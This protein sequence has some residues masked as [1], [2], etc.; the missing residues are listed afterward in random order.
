[1][2]IC[3]E[4]LGD[5]VQDVNEK[6]NVDI[7]HELCWYYWRGRWLSQACPVYVIW[8]VKS[9]CFCWNCS[10]QMFMC[11]E[12]L[13]NMLYVW[14]THLHVLSHEAIVMKARAV[15]YLLS[16]TMF[17]TALVSWKMNLSSLPERQL[18]GWS[19]FLNKC[20]SEDLYQ[21]IF[22]LTL[23]CQSLVTTW[24]WKVVNKIS[25]PKVLLYY[26]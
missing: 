14:T 15:Y 24:Q 22:S 12:I 11:L 17:T 5:K 6:G 8:A 18:Y 19:E 3:I 26:S 20:C 1:M 9:V 23:K 4:V 16:W 13:E 25:T 21:H 7:I 2:G 10:V